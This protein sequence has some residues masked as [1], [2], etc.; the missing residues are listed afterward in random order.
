M[1]VTSLRPCKAVKKCPFA[2]LQSRF[3]ISWKKIHPP[4]FVRQCVWTIWSWIKQ[5]RHIFVTKST[6][7]VK[8]NICVYAIYNKYDVEA[9]N[10]SIYLAMYVVKKKCITYNYYHQFWIKNAHDNSKKV[11][12]RLKCSD[13]CFVFISH[14]IFLLNCEKKLGFNFL[15]I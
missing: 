11:K 14:K 6:V 13:Y 1:F 10:V 2:S 7:N 3:K 5:N 12:Q 15:M 8:I 4:N 9:N